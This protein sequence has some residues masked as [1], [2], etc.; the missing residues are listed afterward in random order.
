[1]AYY[2]IVIKLKACFHV[3]V[4]ANV[5]QTQTQTQNVIPYVRNQSMYTDANRKKYIY[6]MFAHYIYMY[7]CIYIYI[8]IY[9]YIHQK[10]IEFFNNISRTC[11]H[12]HTHSPF[13][14]KCVT[15]LN[16]VMPNSPFSPS[17]LPQTPIPQSPLP[18]TSSLLPYKVSAGLR[19]RKKSLTEPFI[20]HTQLLSLS[21]RTHVSRMIKY[22]KVRF[23]LSL[24]V[25]LRLSLRL[26]LSTHGS[27]PLMVI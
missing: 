10:Y 14:S 9:I 24:S 8:Y 21:L 27:R 11:I 18:P 1:M 23:I 22:S 6:V 15:L 16:K 4:S 12:S 3:S 26:S 19:K 13:K 2:P 17:P 20:A 5:T 25:S 7:I